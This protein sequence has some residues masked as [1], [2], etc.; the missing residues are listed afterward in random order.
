MK[1]LF[2][3][4]AALMLGTPAL[5]HGVTA[6]KIEIIHPAIAA[7]PPSAKSAA[8]YMRIAN[9]GDTAD[10]LIGVETGAANANMLHMTEVGADGVA[11]MRHLDGI[12]LPPGQEVLLEPG[13]IHVM[14]MGL[15]GP[16]ALGDLVPGTL[17]FEKAGRVAVEFSVDAPGDIGHSGMGH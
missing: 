5:A 6:G 9:Q 7:P 17:I 16:L 15:T 2:G 1:P 4:L 12:D 3:L 8:G 14:L 10:R 11:R 13:G